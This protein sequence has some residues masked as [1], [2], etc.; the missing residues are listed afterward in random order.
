LFYFFLFVF[1]IYIYIY[2]YIYIM[3]PNLNSNDVIMSCRNS[4]F[5]LTPF[6][7]RRGVTT[8]GEE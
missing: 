5:S 3:L 1:D 2:I 7:K 6:C 8:N 4:K